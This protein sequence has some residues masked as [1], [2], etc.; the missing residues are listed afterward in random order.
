MAEHILFIV[1]GERTESQ[2]VNNL[3]NYFI[4]KDSV[5]VKASYKTDIYNLYARL[6][7]DED[8]TVFNLVQERDTSLAGYKR[9]QFAQVYLFFDHDPHIQQASDHKIKELLEFFNEETEHG[10]LFVSYP[11]VEALKCCKPEGIT[12]QLLTLVYPI[13]N[14]SS[15]KDYVHNYISKSHI[16]L[17]R[18]SAQD[19]ND[20]IILHSRKLNFMFNNFDNLQTELYEQSKILE[21]QIEKFV[22]VNQ[23]VSVLGGFPIMLI[24]YYGLEWLEKL[25][26]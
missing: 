16:D 5:V 19:W 2:I 15:F 13:C 18:Y 3:L 1:E 12:E 8:L 20:I 26:V 17:T 14:G 10:K 25:S 7:E 23:S 11:M 4:Q 9:S 24:D 21:V 22:T 6:K